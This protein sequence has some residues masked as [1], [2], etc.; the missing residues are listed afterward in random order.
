MKDPLAL[1][2]PPIGRRKAGRAR[3]VIA[4]VTAA[5]VAGSLLQA[6]A[7]AAKPKPYTPPTVQKYPTVAVSNI[8]P[9]AVRQ[10][11]M[12]DG[13]KKPA[14]VW[15]TAGAAEVAVPG[16]AS[17]PVR[18]AGLPV[19]VAQ[20]G[21]VR[22]AGKR[23]VGEAPATVGVRVLDRTATEKAGVRGVLLRVG[24]ADRKSTTAAV[25]LTVDYSG[26]RTAY[27]GDWASR[28]RL[29]AMP[30]CALTTPQRVACAGTPLPSRNDPKAGTVT[31][32]VGLPGDA[33]TTSTAQAS[34][35]VAVA[36]ATSGEAGSF[37]ATSL[38]PSSTW[39]AGGSSGDF[40]WSYPMRVPPAAGAPVPALSL[41]YSA[42][43]VD[44]RQAASNNQPSW[45]GEGFDSSVGGFIERRYEQ[46]QDDMGNGANNTTKTGDM[47]WA[48]DNATLSLAGHSGE[49]IYNSSEQ[50]WHLRSDDGSR[51]ER[52]TGAS[53][54]DDDGEY[55]VVTTTDGTQYW[56]GAHQLPGWSSGG[57]VTNSA[58]TMPVYGNHTGEP[59]H[60]TAFADSSC[61]QAWRWNL[62]YVVDLNGNS[63]SYWYATDTNKYARNMTSSS[64]VGYIRDGHLDHIEYGTRRD[65]GVDSRFTA[66][67]PARV[68]FGVADRCLSGCSTHD[69]AHWPDTP[70]DQEC[71]GSTCDT[72]SPSFWSTKRL[73][74]IT[75]KIWNG[76]AYDSVDR[77]TLTHT[78]PDPGDG[79]RAGLWLS[80]LS[81]T[82]LAGSTVSVPDV[83]FTGVQLSNRVD[84]IDFAAAMNW[85]RIS[86]IR[87][88]T[89]GTVT[90]TYSDPECV[91]Q[92]NVP[93][94]PA[95]N[96]KRCY[97]VRWTPEGYADPVTDYFHKYVV[98]TVVEADNTGGPAPKGSPPVIYRYSYLDSPAWHYTDDDGLIEAKDKTWSVWRGY[99]R[100]GV[101]V[102]DTGE[103]QTYTETK[104]LRGMHGDRA[105]SG[106]RT[107]TVT[108]TGVSTVNDEDA[109][110]GMTRES[111]VYNGP[112]GAVVSRQVTE[113]WQSAATASRT[114][115]GDI[116]QARFTRAA[117]THDR[118]VLDGGRGERVRSVRNTFDAYG[119]TVATD[120]AGDTGVSGDETCTKTTYEPRNTTAWLMS[121]AHRGLTLAVSCASAG[122]LT[123]L[124]DDDV[125]S[126]T[127]VFFDGATTWGTT[128]TRGLVTRTE[129]ANA[130]NAG[131]PTYDQVSRAAYDTSGRIT[132]AW[133]AL[134]HHSTTVYTPTAGGL[135]TQTVLTNALGHQTTTTINPA[136]GVPTKV[137]DP[138][139]K[140]TETT[141]DGLG[142][143]TAVWNPGRDKATQT[144][145]ST[146]TYL[147]SN[148]TP[149]AV[150]TSTLN[151]AG[152]YLASYT[153][154]DG[155][156]RQRQTQTPSPSAGR[157]LTDVFYGTAGRQTREH[158]SY[159]AAGAPS[160]ALSTATDRQ[161]VPNQTRLVYDGAEIGRASCRE[162]V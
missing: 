46:C 60:A 137:V 4:A 28:L 147:V 120:D 71:T 69:E 73:A 75:T 101:T 89:G 41:S 131:S 70:W 35:L 58:W 157:L 140:K 20:P 152:N 162:R 7:W 156:L 141:Y 86:Q 44:G 85:W 5:V 3:R 126:D 40:S 29:L 21:T 45:V 18:A 48:T 57:A 155:L 130:W 63:A 52:R 17:Q 11:A 92:T 100:V 95:S 79:T 74:T 145:N 49:L 111:T 26:F 56:F 91:A 9:V 16:P 37:A 34:T 30:A 158:G 99:S 62:D 76:S 14:P 149:S 134:D 51:I 123:A 122:D 98:T 65:N 108:G 118:T 146:F 124:A 109:Y 25:D 148:T 2:P 43:S 31:A 94:E 113:P 50:R 24:R 27:G 96:T 53:N 93:T 6:P 77:W 88:E 61:T 15:P 87:Y 39:S 125:V 66:S 38:Q 82:G 12:P 151:A 1:I 133:D 107:V 19:R 139:G 23:V 153:L 110:A 90:V 36:A 143:L 72:Y 105:A 127:R 138:N 32:T 83:E 136:W 81:H 42:Q 128:P 129:Q 8:K 106:T 97:P 59:C 119:M 132:D 80:K 144:P 104:Y 112:G 33:A 121:A 102:G 54:G 150:G 68:D 103:Q 142:R 116:V 84:T 64:V 55:W 135:V 159:V 67:A 13:T 115:N 10:A 160:A 161:E 117:A 114:V 22:T 47:C 78:F 154:Y